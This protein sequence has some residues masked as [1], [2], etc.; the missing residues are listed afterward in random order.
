MRTATPARLERLFARIV[1]AMVP[2][3]FVVGALACGAA[4]GNAPADSGTTNEVDARASNDDAQTSPSDAAVSGDGDRIPDAGGETGGDAFCSQPLSC[5]P[6]LVTLDGGLP[7]ANAFLDANIGGFGPGPEVD[8]GPSHAECIA[9]CSGYVYG[10][11]IE[12][13]GPPIVISCQPEC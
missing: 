6:R 7:D 5:C 11:A 4:T 10:C 9:L 1:I 13:L 3:A 2:G 8:G 12:S